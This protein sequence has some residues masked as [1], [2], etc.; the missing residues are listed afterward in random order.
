MRKLNWLFFAFALIVAACSPMGT[1]EPTANLDESASAAA[2]GVSYDTQTITLSDGSKYDITANVSWSGS[3]TTWTYLVKGQAGA[4][5]IS[6]IDFLG[7]DPCFQSNLEGAGITFA[8]EGA[9]CSEVT[10]QDVYKFTPGTAAE[11]VEKTF[12][13]TFNSALGVDEEAAKIYVKAGSDVGGNNGGCEAVTVPG[14]SCE[15]L[16]ISGNATEEN[17]DGTTS[18]EGAYAGATVTAT[19]EG[20]EPLETETDADGNYSFPNIAGTW[21]VTME[22]AEDS[23]E[24]TVGPASAVANFAVDNRPNGSCAEITGSV[25][26]FD[27]DGTSSTHTLTGA[28]TLTGTGDT[29]Y[30]DETSAVDGVYSFSNVPVGTYTVNYAGQSVDVTVTSESGSNA[31][32]AISV[33]NRPNGTCAAVVITVNLIEC[34][35]QRSTGAQL[36]AGASVTL[37]GVAGTYLNGTFTF[38]NVVAGTYSLTVSGTDRSGNDVTETRSVVVEGISGVTT[39]TFTFDTTLNGA[40]GTDTACSLSQGYWFA[41]PQSTWGAGLTI[42]GYTYTKAEGVAIWNSANKG[43]LKNAK[44]AF[45]QAAAIIL[46]GVDESASVWADVQIVQ[47]Y[48][49]SLGYKLTAN[50][51]PNNSKTGL[52][53]AAGA[54]AG[55]I[56]QWID[57]NHCAE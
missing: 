39:A 45:T 42:G 24:V 15:V 30:G 47:N 54:A 18:T 27:C 3:T 33:D 28:V 7:L 43:G 44:A 8:P 25:E 48:L 37:N 9:S 50:N 26:R 21:T 22:G 32:D 52:N 16:G 40:C 51:I 41:K 12:T 49:S 10:G 19:Q 20:S 31:A 23:Q 29:T 53:A 6:H 38:S 4:K 34:F 56:G 11:E 5:A 36:W 13:F 35:E 55:R 46:S 2:F 14:P 57:A 1:E 17:C